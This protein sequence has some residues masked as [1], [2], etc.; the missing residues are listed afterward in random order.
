VSNSFSFGIDVLTNGVPDA[1]TTKKAALKPWLGVDPFHMAGSGLPNSPRYTA[2]NMLDVVLR[3]QTN[4]WLASGINGFLIPDSWAAPARDGNGYRVASNFFNQGWVGGWTDPASLQNMVVQ[5]RSAGISPAIYTAFR[6]DNSGG[7]CMSSSGAD[8]AHVQQDSQFYAAMGFEMVMQDMCQSY[9][10]TH[11]ALQV[12]TLRATRNAMTRSGRQMGL[13]YVPVQ[14]WSGVP[15]PIPSEYTNSCNTI[16]VAGTFDFLPTAYGWSNAVWAVKY[17]ITNAYTTNIGSWWGPG[18]HPN[19]GN[20]GYPQ[21]SSNAP[22][23]MS[24]MAMSSESVLFGWFGPDG[25]GAAS[26]DTRYLTNAE[27][28]AINQDDGGRMCFVA[29]T[30]NLTEVMLKPLGPPGVTNAWAVALVNYLGV[31]T[32]VTLNWSMFGGVNNPQFFTIRDNIWHTNW[33]GQTNATFTM[34]VPKSS[35]TLLTFT[36][37]GSV[38]VSNLVTGGSFSGGFTNTGNIQSGGDMLI[39]G[40]NG[41]LYTEGSFNGWLGQMQDDNSSQYYIL[42][43]AS[44]L[45]LRMSYNSFNTDLLQIFDPGHNGV[46]YMTWNGAAWGQGAFTNTGIMYLTN[47]VASFASDAT[48]QINLTGWTNTLG[49]SAWVKYYATNCFVTN[50]LST[51]SPPTVWFTHGNSW[52]TSTNPITD[53]L[54]PGESIAASAA[55]LKGTAKPF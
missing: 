33:V 29:A 43:T 27:A 7:T 44:A 48:V 6:P 15:I 49:K 19:W 22:T 2:T 55:S 23:F 25:F 16:N 1:I 37:V 32:N 5:F 17:C 21:D 40:G 4:G 14:G 41:R 12:P 9:D 24:M 31:N 42:G 35:A 30:N 38:A 46:G 8:Y 28:I 26:D 36:P 52:G 34:S 11:A 53:I 45:R 39:A 18:L 47:G 13:I 50:K 10:L 3:M 20:Y 51:G 54:Q